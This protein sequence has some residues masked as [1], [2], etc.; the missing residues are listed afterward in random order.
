MT[1]GA[2]ASYSPYS[3]AVFQL[4]SLWFWPLFLYLFAAAFPNSS[5]HR[6]DPRSLPGSPT[7]LV[8]SPIVQLSALCRHTHGNRMGM[9]PFLL[10]FLLFGHSSGLCVLRSRHCSTV[11]F[12]H[13]SIV[14]LDPFHS[15]LSWMGRIRGPTFVLWEPHLASS[16]VR[17]SPL[18][19]S[20]IQ[21]SLSFSS[22]PRE[23]NHRPSFA[24]SLLVLGLCFPSLWSSG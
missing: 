18:S 10:P 5:S 7:L 3:H 8:P 4:C 11:F 9:F 16:C 1:H 15:D 23:P 22:L 6:P 2:Y 24:P 19:L 21:P 14:A 17:Q 20:F 12:L 13:T